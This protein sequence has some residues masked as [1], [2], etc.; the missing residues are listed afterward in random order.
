MELNLKG[1][2]ASTKTDFEPNRKF[3][4]VIARDRFNPVNRI[5]H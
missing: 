3:A 2:Y 5:K 1:A 4:T